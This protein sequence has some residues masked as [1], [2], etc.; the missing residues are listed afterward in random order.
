MKNQTKLNSAKNCLIRNSVV[1]NKS[2]GKV[3]IRVLLESLIFKKGY[4]TRGGNR[5]KKDRDY[6]LLSYIV[7]SRANLT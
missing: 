1:C 2:V 4:V 6:Y 7:L 3:E 5:P